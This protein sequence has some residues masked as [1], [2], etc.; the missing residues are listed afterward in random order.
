MTKWLI[1]DNSLVKD[2]KIEYTIPEK[3]LIHAS[4][5]EDQLAEVNNDN[6]HEVNNDII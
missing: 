5:N 6:R 4:C 1:A 3:T 2:G